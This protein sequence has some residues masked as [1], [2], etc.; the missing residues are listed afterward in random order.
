MIDETDR[1]RP[2]RLD[3]F[4]V[5]MDSDKWNGRFFVQLMTEE[6]KRYSGDFAISNIKIH[7][8]TKETFNHY[9]IDERYIKANAVSRYPVVV[10][11]NAYPLQTKFEKFYDNDET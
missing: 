7:E 4:K 2:L 5:Q 6:P 1:Y 9:F 11:N 8:V 3:D 10:I